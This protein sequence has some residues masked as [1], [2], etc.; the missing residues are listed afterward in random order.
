MLAWVECSGLRGSNLEDGGKHMITFPLRDQ[1]LHQLALVYKPY[2][3]VLFS[4]N[5]ICIFL[6]QSSESLPI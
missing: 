1:Q 2:I 3:N 5:L 4:F 6:S